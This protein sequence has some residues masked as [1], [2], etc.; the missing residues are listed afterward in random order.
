[1][2]ETDLHQLL[3]NTADAA[4]IIGSDCLIRYWNS[5]AEELFG[6]RASAVLGR[7]CCSVM[8]GREQTGAV[9]C[10]PDCAVVTL[11]PRR[12]TAPAF[13]MSV[14]TAKGESHWVN[15]STLYA[16]TYR[17]ERLVVHLAR[18]IDARKRLEN[19]TRSFLAQ[20]AGLSGEKIE[21]LLHSSP[22]PHERLTQREKE[23]TRHLAQG[24]G[25]AAIARSLHLA[26]ATVRNHVR[27]ILAKLSVHSRTEAALRAIREKLI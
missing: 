15:V 8:Q 13:D 21:D 11:N 9:V 19:V 16:E 2:Q 12:E 1:M 20:I 18:D 17:G 22:T 24:H 14:K 10:T 7:S 25:T 26:P 6:L 4:F 5:A 27:N 3:A 23:I